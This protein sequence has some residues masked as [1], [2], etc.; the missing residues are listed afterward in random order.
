MNQQAEHT[1]RRA[2]EERR[3]HATTETESLDPV[4]VQESTGRK[5]DTL[6]A[7]RQMP[8]RTVLKHFRVC[9]EKAKWKLE[10]DGNSLSL[11]RSLT[12]RNKSHENLRGGRRSCRFWLVLAEAGESTVHRF[13]PVSSRS[14]QLSFRVPPCL[15]VSFRL[16]L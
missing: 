15:P 11:A 8:P 7:A 3:T 9:S 10:S 14:F 13:H 1:C 5:V 6:R 4:Q 2:S 16:D 12:H